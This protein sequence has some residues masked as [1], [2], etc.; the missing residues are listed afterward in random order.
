VGADDHFSCK[1][2]DKVVPLRLFSRGDIEKNRMNKLD[3]FASG[4]ENW[5]PYNPYGRTCVIQLTDRLPT[6]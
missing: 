2:N 3:H 1:V 4:E 6:G 5:T